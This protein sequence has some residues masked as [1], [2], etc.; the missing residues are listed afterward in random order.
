[1]SVNDQAPWLEPRGEGERPSQDDVSAT[2]LTA[3]HPEGLDD[4]VDEDEE[5]DDEADVPDEDAICDC[6]HRALSHVDK[7]LG[8][9]TVPVNGDSESVEPGDAALPVEHCPCD[10]FV[11]W[12]LI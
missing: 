4:V 1:M 12:E 8:Y 3:R 2:G 6:S 10:K 11:V 9:C 5:F 7:G